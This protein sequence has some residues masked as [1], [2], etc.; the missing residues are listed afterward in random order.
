[1]NM[2]N[3]LNAAI[4]Y[5]E[6]NLCEKIDPEEIARITCVSQDSFLRFFSYM[7]GMTLNE[8]IR[9]RRL[10]QAALELQNGDTR[11]IDA[12]LK[13]GYESADAFARAF[14]KQ[15]GIS[16]AAAKKGGSL[17]IY[18]P[19]SFHIIIKGAKKMNF[20][21]VDVKETVVLGV[22]KE[23]DERAFA[24]REELRHV[25]WSENGDDVPRQICEGRWNEPGRHSYDG[26]WYG[27]WSNGRYLIGREKTFVK[28][29]SF[30]S[31][32]IPEGRY[33]AFTSERGGY[34]GDEIPKLWSLIFDSWLP[35][36][37]YA[38]RDEEVIEVYHLWNDKAQRKKN[39]YYEI[40]IPMVEK[41]LL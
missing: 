8:Y 20:R 34:A 12:A 32:T 13:Y 4:R 3:E 17:K 9:R 29:E 19:A 6:E 36:S 37:G 10:S 35:D 30:E 14:A 25:M 33:A 39:R 23:F 27:V 41:Q 15:H 18:P 24:S 7:T 28:N 1:M 31:L 11:V 26:I 40:W 2:P 22:S 16:P 38:L 5:V 21:M